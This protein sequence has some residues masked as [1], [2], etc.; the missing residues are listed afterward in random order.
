[1]VHIKTWQYNVPLF[2]TKVAVSSI[3]SFTSP[4]RGFSG[5]FFSET[6]TGRLINAAAIIGRLFML[7]G[8]EHFDMLVKDGK[9][10]WLWSLRGHEPWRRGSTGLIDKAL[11]KRLQWLHWLSTSCNH[12]RWVCV[13]VM[14]IKIRGVN[15]PEYLSSSTTFINIVKLSNLH[16]H[17][18]ISPKTIVRLDS[19]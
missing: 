3:T 6:E 8:G 13:S 11:Y 15:V 4:W 5:E 2:S 18:V 16:I 10:R 7:G 1:M 19:S 14:A 17:F 12:H 9:W